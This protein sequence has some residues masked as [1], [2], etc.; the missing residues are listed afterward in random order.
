VG[1]FL[2]HPKTSPKL[3]RNHGDLVHPVRPDLVA[4][5][6]FDE[7]PPVYIGVYDFTKGIS[8]VHMFLHRGTQSRKTP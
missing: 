4:L 8:L 5:G 1:Y 3:R 6:P 2:V 7:I